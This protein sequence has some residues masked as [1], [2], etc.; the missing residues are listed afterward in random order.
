MAFNH[1]TIEQKWQNYW[2][3]NKTFKTGQETDKP[4]F[5][6]L[7]MFPYPSGSGLHVG[8]PEG[9]TATDIISRMKRMQ[10]YN[11][12]HPMGWDA[13]G[14]PAEQYALD[15]G[16]DP[17]DFTDKNIGV[18]RKQIQSLGFSYDWD[19]EINTTDP[20][21]YKWTQWIFTQLHNMGL[22]EIRESEVNWCEALGTVLANEEVLNEDGKMVSE[23]GS[24]PVI[25]KPM[26]Q[27]MLKIT[28]YAE[29]LLADLDELDWPESLK[30]MQRNWI[31]KSEGA[32]INF[33]VAGGTDSFDVFTTRPDTL[34]GATYVVLAPEHPL[35][36]TITNSENSEA[37][38]A[39]QEI[40]KAKT[41]LER[42]E[43]NKIK[44]GV[45]TGAKAVHPIT[46]ELLPIWIGDY[47][48][49]SYGAGAVMAVPGHDERDFEFA[50]KY[51]LPIVQVL[52]GDI[53]EAAFTGDA[54][55]INSD[56]VN[57]MV[58]AE[59][60]SAIIDWLE[61]NQKGT[62]KINYKLRD[63]LFAR[64]R[65]WGE[66][67]PVIH[68]ED[69][70]VSVLDESELPLELP[71]MENIKPSGTG[72]SPL[73][74]AT[75]W[76]E[77]TR[78]D[79]VKGR[80]ET[81]TMPQWAG[82]CWYYIGYILKSENGFV[83]LNTEEAKT[84]LAKW[85]PV[86]LYIGGAE[87]A[88]L[89]LLYARFW[90][91]VLYDLQVVQQK[92]PFQKLFN[93]GMILGENNEKM[94]KS[95]GNVVNP[96]DVVASHGADTLRLYEM[97]M[98][99][100]ES[101]IAW[102][103]EGLDG[104]RRFLDRV[105]RLIISENLTI[106]PKITENNDGNLD[107]VYHETVKKVTE[108]YEKLGFNTAIAQ[109]M[110][111]INEA[112]KAEAVPT[113]YIEGFLKLLNPIAPHVT[114]E[115]WQLLG[116]QGSITYEPWPTYD[117][118]KLVADTITVIAQ[119]NGKLRAKLEVPAAISKDDMEKLALNHENVLNF[120]TGKNIAKVIVVPGK[121]VNIVVK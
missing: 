32:L 2:L 51:A 14:L 34:F 43:L 103:T 72:E 58:N 101:A 80:R 6:A 21:Y 112:Y 69:G 85:L 86:D 15:T 45:D 62:K 121:L 18:F 28:H 113:E 52:E 44:T 108:D 57:G 64:Q 65:Y 26:K 91:K 41:D 79:G 40:S 68:W 76:L 87:H 49:A 119:V 24:H 50:Q 42:T 8:H 47:V 67:F 115:I 31:G 23:R 12:L 90:H 60:K 78:A 99:P 74:N 63:W 11:V 27:W 35:V 39:Y 94:S 77:V 10:G 102:S 33:T 25:K 88:V 89:H 56:F 107:K 7:D 37:V 22:A 109:M 120:T 82:S 29:R 116:H 61:A 98:G 84:A 16:N 100:L 20:E 4:K 117:E 59:A 110:I 36:K 38:K 83:G 5:Y 92:E 55:H 75:D 66:P 81:N 48:L 71:I 111:F 54:P 1:N 70:T 118:A 96:D 105:W 19:K 13:F 106:N 104:S 46:G 17:R 9:Y 114:E 97:F 93:Q 53:S 30:E 3:A 73:A 95:K